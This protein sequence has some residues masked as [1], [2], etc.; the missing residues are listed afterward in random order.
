[1]P[2]GVRTSG[3]TATRSTTRENDASVGPSNVASYEQWVEAFQR[4]CKA[5]DR[6]EELRCPNCGARALRLLFVVAEEDDGDGRAVFWC[7]D[8]RYGLMPNRSVVPPGGRR[9]TDDP[10]VPDYKIVPPT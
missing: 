4:A 5:P 7:D 9:V 8:C 3:G 6:L 10:E 2:S 1:M